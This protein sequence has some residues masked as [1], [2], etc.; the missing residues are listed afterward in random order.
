MGAVVGVAL[1]GEELHLVAAGG[2]GVVEQSLEESG[3]HAPAAVVGGDP[4]RLDEGGGPAL[5]GEVRQQ[6]EAHRA[7][8]L[9]VGL[10]QVHGHVRRG[11]DAGR[12]GPLDV[13]RAAGSVVQDL[14][15]RVEVSVGGGPHHVHQP[16]SASPSASSD[17]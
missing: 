2:A 15:H 5:V 6:Q 8:R 7:D 4:H 13:A 17:P 16:D 3:G 10:G 12:R 1:V 14:E 11:P 9:A